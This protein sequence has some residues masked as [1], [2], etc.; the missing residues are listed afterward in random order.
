MLS[1]DASLVQ[2][3]WRCGLGILVGLAGCIS[4]ETV[5]FPPPIAATTDAPKPPPN[6]SLQPQFISAE[7]VDSYQTFVLPTLSIQE[8]S[9]RWS[10]TYKGRW[11]KWSGQLLYFSRDGLQFRQLAQTQSFDVELL[12]PEPNR[13]ALRSQLTLGRFYNYAGRLVRVDSSFR[14]IALDQGTVFSAN[15]VGVP[16]TLANAP[17]PTRKLGPQPQL[18]APPAELFAL[19]SSSPGSTAAQ[20]P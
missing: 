19:P 16:G 4:Q 6:G 18:C 20:V 13:S 14:V 9:K 17:L 2:L 12:V 15:E 8:A 1:R 11:V 5:S 3:V 10:S 7:F